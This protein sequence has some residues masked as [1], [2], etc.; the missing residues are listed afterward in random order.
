M[1]QADVEQRLA[2]LE[3]EIMRLQA[4]NEIQNL[5]GKYESIHNVTDVWRSWEI[6]ARH[7]T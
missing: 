1:S 4:I 5:I 2:Q 6:F 3:H 7:T